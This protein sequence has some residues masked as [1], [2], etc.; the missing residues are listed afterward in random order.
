MK[1]G[2]LFSIFLIA[3]LFIISGNSAT[4]NKDSNMQ[5]DIEPQ[6]SNQQKQLTND[7]E[8]G[9]ILKTDNV[10][11]DLKEPKN[12]QQIIKGEEMQ[13]VLRIDQKLVNVEWADNNAVKE[14][15]RLASKNNISIDTTLYGG[16]EQVGSLGHSLPTKD[17]N[18]TTNPGDIMLYNG[19]NIVVFFGE[20]TWSY[21]RL[22]KIQGL[23]DKELEEL[24]GKPS[25]KIIISNDE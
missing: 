14:L 8:N 4:L 19:N 21:T 7:K 11:F 15:K 5:N 1:R 17:E 3:S 18:I 23:S 22:G 16:F 13:L 2:Y 12:K 24:L 9:T 25:T 10:S 6:I 20:N